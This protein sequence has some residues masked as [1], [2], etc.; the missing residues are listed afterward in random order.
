MLQRATTQGK[1]QKWFLFAG[2]CSSKVQ[3]ARFLTSC[4]SSYIK[5]LY[6]C[7]CN[8]EQVFECVLSILQSDIAVFEI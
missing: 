3:L 7:S 5:E 6:L 8:P 4:L 1:F 2:G